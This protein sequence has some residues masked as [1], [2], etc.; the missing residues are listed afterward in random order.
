MVFKRRTEKWEVIEEWRKDEKWEWR[1][2]AAQSG[3]RVK[4]KQFN[5][6]DFSPF[7]IY[8]HVTSLRLS[9][10]TIPIIQPHT[11]ECASVNEPLRTYGICWYR[12]GGNSGD[13]TRNNK[14]GPVA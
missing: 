3:R 7:S 2:T 14:I 1:G 10:D 5:D 12:E 11:S 13:S 8:G 9:T 4:D 6:L